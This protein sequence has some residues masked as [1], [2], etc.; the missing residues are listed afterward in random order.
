V[1]LATPQAKPITIDLMMLY[2]KRAESRS[3]WIDRLLAVSV[4]Q[5]NETF[6]NSGLGNIVLRLVHTQAVNYDES[7][8]DHFDH[9]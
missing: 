7:T 3:L 1:R 2:A 6:R 9:L 4:E 5:V 8:G